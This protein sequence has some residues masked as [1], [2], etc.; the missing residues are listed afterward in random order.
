MTLG[1]DFAYRGAIGL[2]QFNDLLISA[3]PAILDPTQRAP[4]GR[5]AY[6]S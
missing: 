6:C 5:A 3:V 2:I 1:K 4:D